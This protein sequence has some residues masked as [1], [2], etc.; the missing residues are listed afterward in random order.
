MSISIQEIGETLNMVA[1]QNLDVRTITMGINTMGCAD[2]DIDA[3]A[4][5]VY[6]RMTTAAEHLVEVA[7][8]LEREYGIP[9]V[10][11]RIS[12]TPM[13]QIA[14]A[15]KA[16]DLTPLARAMDRAAEA[17]GVDFVGGFS[18]L[19]QKGIGD[20]DLRL[21]DS[22]PEALSTTT[23]VCSSV[24]L[25]SVRAG[26][27]MDAV[28]KMAEIILQTAQATVDI[29]CYG[30]A[31][32]V[33]F[34]NMVEDSPFMAGAIHGGGEGDEVINVGVS[35]PGVMAAALRN[36]PKTADMQTV[37]ETIK[38]TAFKITRVGELMAREASR[39]LGVQMGI[40]D[41]SLAPTPAVGDSVADVLEAIGVGTC[42]GP[43]T[44][45]ALAMLNDAVKKG[46]VMASSSVGGLS[47]AFIP[48]SED[49][50]MIRAVEARALSLEKLEA[51]TCVCSVGLDM[52]AVPGDTSVETLAGF[53]ADEMAI[54][55]INN[56]TTAVRVIPAIGK[57]VGD[58]LEFGGLFG[59]APVQEIN[60]HA[61]YTF[62]HRGGRI[63]A[64]LN[65]LKN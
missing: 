55:V 52:V 36:L 46:G 2:E 32:L 11:K 63:P 61:G 33:V 28:L 41:L 23:R 54:G 27:N 21:M 42:G 30:A 43:G 20:A 51:M 34:A 18:A 9:I 49:A 44:T 10:N 3:M 56:K 47:G 19:V 24:N 15:T 17:V 57:K 6:N 12:V 59:S 13:A 53:I 65:S 4:R 16:R 14:A 45:A 38:A 60:G 37:A 5:K 39:R 7:E 8:A 25:A 22:I 1:Q 64:P 26:I 40:V 31:K 48:V 50:G 62:A 29:N 35:G 58:K